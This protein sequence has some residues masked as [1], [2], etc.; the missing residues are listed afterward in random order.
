MFFDYILAALQRAN[1]TSIHYGLR[2][3]FGSWKSFVARMRASKRT[4]A[5]PDLSVAALE[6]ALEQW[7]QESGSFD[8]Q[9]HLRFF[10]D[11]GWKTSPPSAVAGLAA[12]ERLFKNLLVE[13]PTAASHQHMAAFF[14]VLTMKCSR[15]CLT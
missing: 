5:N 1:S 15:W 11:V 6:Q 9:H 10:V 14:F 7:L 8:A 3:L 2:L 13:E 4:R 12:N